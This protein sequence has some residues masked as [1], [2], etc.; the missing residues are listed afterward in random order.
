I[1]VRAA[2]QLNGA[3]ASPANLLDRAD[4]FLASHGGV[5]GLSR[6]YGSDKTFRVPILTNCALAGTVT[7]GK[8]PALPFELACLPPSLYAA[9]RLPVVSY[10]IPALVAVGLVRFRQAPPRNPLTRWLRRRAVQG[11]LRMLEQMQPASGGF[12]EATPLTSFVVMSLSAAGEVAHPAVR[13]GVDFLC[14]SVRPCGGWPIDTNLATWVTTL[15]IQALAAGG[16]EDVTRDCLPWL[17][18]CQHRQVHPAT[19]AAPGGWA[20]TDLSGGVPDVDDTAG[21]L[22]ALST[23]AGQGASSGEEVLPAIREAAAAGVA[24]LL[25]LQNRDG[26]WPT[27][28][29]G[30][31]KLPFDRS[32]TDLTAHAIRALHAWQTHFDRFGQP[33]TGEGV[34]PPG[35]VGRAVGQGLEYLERHQQPDGS[36]LPL[37]FGNQDRPDQSNPVYGTARVLL[38]YRDLQRL[39]HPA[40]RRGLAW[41][42][43]AQG[44]SG[45]WGSVEETSLAVEALL[46]DPHAT[47]DSE[48]WEAM[49]R[50]LQ[51]LVEAVQ[52]DRHRQPA[53]I[54]FYFAQLWYYEHLYPLVFATSA[55]GQALRRFA[56]PDRFAPED[57][58]RRQLT[59]DSP[60]SASKA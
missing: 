39:D 15:S 4:Q 30:W 57:W 13:R 31:G 1:L 6:L 8:V 41:L 42:Q 35:A 49:V 3:P 45:D 36:W 27:F 59:A 53:P 47:P 22:L 12:L 7:W 5:K 56:P 51:W 14:A 44:R 19:Q 10:A 33:V 38:A 43:A 29:R 60:F 17:L 37:W 40:A 20:W 34:L 24:W 11:A 48:R 9:L 26:G 2:L 55:L 54:G 23:I 32:G 58:P 28:C 25:Q 16:D 46:A 52:D 18:N 50:G 21:A